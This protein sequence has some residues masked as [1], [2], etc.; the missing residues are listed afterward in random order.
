M[1][2]W[3]TVPG[4]YISF[5][6]VVVGTGAVRVGRMIP[7]HVGAIVTVIP[8][9]VVARRVNVSGTRKVAGTG[10]RMST[11]TSEGLD[12]R[13]CDQGDKKQS[14]KRSHQG[15]PLVEDKHPT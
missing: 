15:C 13:T 14:D 6:R 2:S 1:S 9:R 12:R 7:V 8:V 5:G 3:L 10:T 4:I 11:T